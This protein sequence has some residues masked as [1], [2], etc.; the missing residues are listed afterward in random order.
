MFK[1]IM[2]TKC[3]LLK[4]LFSLKVWYIPWDFGG[5]TLCA[6]CFW[7]FI[8]IYLFFFNVSPWRYVIFII[9]FRWRNYHSYPLD[10][11]E[12]VWDNNEFLRDINDNLH[13]HTL[14]SFI[15][16]SIVIYRYYFVA[17]ILNFCHV[18]LKLVD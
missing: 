8:Y 10:N 15:C 2:L 18:T 7:S 1:K 9:S 4:F 12:V 3:N 13:I 14:G 6:L 5:I 16:F 11:N 17:E